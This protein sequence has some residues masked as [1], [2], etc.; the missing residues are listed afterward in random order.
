M[1]DGGGVYTNGPQRDTLVQGNYITGIPSTN[2]V[3]IYLDE[4]SQL[5]DITTT[6]N[7]SDTLNYE[8]VAR[9]VQADGD[10][11]G[12]T[13]YVYSVPTIFD[14]DHPSSAQQRI[15]LDAGLEAEYEDLLDE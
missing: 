14:P 10:Y 7:Y 5:G 13:A 8:V 12:A 3:G 2:G 9:A 1:D 6:N 11:N 4:G 15:I